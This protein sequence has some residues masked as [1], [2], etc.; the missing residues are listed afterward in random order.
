MHHSIDCHIF[1]GILM[2]RPLE[3]AEQRF[4]DVMVS[5]TSDAH[6]ASLICRGADVS[7]EGGVRGSSKPLVLVGVTCRAHQRLTVTGRSSTK[8]QRRVSSCSVYI[9]SSY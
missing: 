3:S 7:N 1:C 2:C 4:I 5:L 8:M 9:H 6:V